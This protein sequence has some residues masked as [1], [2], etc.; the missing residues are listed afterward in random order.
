MTDTHLTLFCLV[1]GETT[2]FPV[3][4]ESTKTIGDLKDLIKTKQTPDFDDIAAKSLTLWRVSLPV[5]P[6]KDRKAISLAEVPSKEELD[7]TD[8]ISDVFEEKPP[9]K[10]IHIIVQRPP[11]VHAPVSSRPSTPLP[12]HLLEKSR[13]NTPL[14]GDLYADIKKITDKF[15]APGPIANFLDA[16]VRGKGTLPVTNGPIRGLPRAWRR[17]MGESPQTRPSLLFLDLPDP[18]VPDLATKNFA[19]GSIFD[20]GNNRPHIPGKQVSMDDTG[21]VFISITVHLFISFSLSST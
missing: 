12:G 5:V 20:K 10:T 11:Q 3:A 2:S 7:E 21:H 18:A 8:D 17:S 9:K 1:N 19:A 6:K 16:F 4:I 13:P 15:F 14:S